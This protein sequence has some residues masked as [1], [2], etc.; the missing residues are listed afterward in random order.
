MFV[1]ALTFVVPHASDDAIGEVSFVGSA[2]FAAGLA[3][4]E[5][6]V[7]VGSC[8]VQ[9]AVL[10][11]AGDVEHAVDPSVATE[12]DAHPTSLPDLD[13]GRNALIVGKGAPSAGTTSH[14]VPE[15]AGPHDQERFASFAL[16]GA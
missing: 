8:F 12:V 9:V 6:A 2:G 14:T 10:D 11:D 7:D 4:A 16:P 1:E 3:F 5:F 15:Q 13:R